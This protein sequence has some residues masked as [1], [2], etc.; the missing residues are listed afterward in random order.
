MKMHDINHLSKFTM[1][2]I[3]IKFSNKMSEDDFMNL[4][5]R[6][7]QMDENNLTLFIEILDIMLALDDEHMVYYIDKLDNILQ[8]VERNLAFQRQREREQHFMQDPFNIDLVTWRGL[9]MPSTT[10]LRFPLTST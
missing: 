3:H 9:T 5:R 2:N 10:S 4:T 1:Y 6:V 7:N 8:G